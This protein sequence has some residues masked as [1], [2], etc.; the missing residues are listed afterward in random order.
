MKAGLSLPTVAKRPKDSRRS[1][2]RE[3]EKGDRRLFAF[4]AAWRSFGIRVGGGNQAEY[5]LL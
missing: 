3:R 5:Y 1:A 4:A 2:E